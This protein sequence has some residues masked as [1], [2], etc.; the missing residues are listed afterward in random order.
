MN[1]K[2]AGKKILFSN[3]PADGHFNPLSGLAKYLTELGCDV[4]WLSSSIC[5][6]KIKKLSIPYYPLVKTLDINATN[7]F[8]LVPEIRTNDAEKRIAIYRIQYALHSSEYFEDIRDIYKSFPFDLIV[9]DSFFPA[10][11]YIKHLLPVPLVAIGI[12]PLAED[13]VD[14]APYGYALWPPKN[15]EERK[16]YADLYQKTPERYLEATNIFE[17]LLAEY[18]VPY[19]RM[20]IENRLI[21]EADVYLQIGAP[22]FEYPRRDIGKNIHFIGALLPYSPED[23]S[24]KWYDPRLQVYSKVILVTQG[25]VEKDSGKLI[26]PTIEAF[27]DT[28]V[29]LIVT[30]GGSR[31]QELRDQYEAENVIIEDF[32][33]FKDV[34][35]YVN[36][37]VTNGGYGGTLLSITHKVP[38]LVAGLHEGKNEVCARVGYFKL[39]IDLKTETPDIATIREGVITI[40]ADQ[41]YKENVSRLAD[42]LNT[43][44]SL[45]LCAEHIENLLGL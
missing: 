40:L 23:Q 20:A 28:N 16:T 30:T 35:P 15:E 21:R 33:P 8:E 25:T 17:S 29:L 37:Y 31:T 45:Q 32:I 6:E 5:A 13:S 38:M 1:S 19:T 41:Q 12:V 7:I 44:H 10:I 18:G 39:G 24:K 14:T 3:V 11:P 22:E 36:V 27:R 34:M 42:T 4:R 9:V 2:L 43:Y 26:I